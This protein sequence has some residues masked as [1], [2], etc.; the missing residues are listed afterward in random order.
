MTHP[1]GSRVGRA[2]AAAMAPPDGALALAR[3]APAVWSVA[4]PRRPLARLSPAPRP[5]GAGAP[6]T[7]TFSK[8]APRQGAEQWE[9]F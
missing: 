6:D 9:Q 2:T 3:Y 7:S 8:P 4:A 5:R 1:T